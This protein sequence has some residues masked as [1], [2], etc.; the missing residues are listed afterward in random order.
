MRPSKFYGMIVKIKNK[1]ALFTLL[2]KKNAQNLVYDFFQN[3]IVL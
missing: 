1:I 2:A 3:F